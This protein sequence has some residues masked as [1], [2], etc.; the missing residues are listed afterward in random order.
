L[1]SPPGLNAQWATPNGPF[2]GSQIVITGFSEENSGVYTATPFIGNCTGDP[3][4]ATVDFAEPLPFSLG[5][6]TS[7]CIGG[8]YSLMIPAWY[9]D[10]L[11][12]T[13]AEVHVIAVSDEGIFIAQAI[14]SN[15]CV[16]Q[17]EVS[18]SALDCEP[19][20]PNVISP[21]G[22]GHNDVF[23]IIGSEGFTLAIRIY[24]R[25]GMVVWEYSGR[26]IRW[27]GM[28]QNGDAV[29]DGVYYYE[30]SRTG[31]TVAGTYTGYIHVL[32]GR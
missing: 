2:T 26:D 7:F 29:P 20:I 14:D 3:V 30:L 11:W 9:T 12:S 1:V 25:W 32:K 6:D 13:G 5:P 31:A 18:I 4:S 27:N 23:T 24:N 19:V 22:D 17:D 15:G 21:N 16:V 28:H 8:Y 10:P